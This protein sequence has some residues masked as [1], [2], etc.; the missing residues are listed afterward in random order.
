MK[1]KERGHKKENI[2]KRTCE[3][4]TYESGHVKADI[5][6]WTYGRKHKKT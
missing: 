4:R 5:R 6:K 1:D 3:K 2:R